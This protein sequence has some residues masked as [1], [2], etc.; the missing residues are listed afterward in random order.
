MAADKVSVPAPVLVTEPVDVAIAPEMVD[1]PTDSTVKPNVPDTPP[2]IVNVEP[3]STC[4]SA[5]AV[6]VT[7][8]D[9]VFEP[10]VL[11]NAPFDDT[12]VPA[13]YNGSVTP[14]SPPETVT[15][16]PLATV[17]YDVDDPL[18]PRAVLCWTSTIPVDTVVRPVNVFAPVSVNV[19]EPVFFFNSPAPEI[20]PVSFWSVSDAYRNVPES[21]IEMVFA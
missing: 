3:V 21:P 5:A 7:A 8:P 1:D 20:T 10:E 11:R 13:R 16:A 9:H 4:T 17:V 18:S 14:V 2:D 6:N 19:L 15:A 12:P